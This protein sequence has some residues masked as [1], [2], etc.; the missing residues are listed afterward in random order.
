MVERGLAFAIRTPGELEAEFTP[1]WKN[2]KYRL[3]IQD[4]LLD[5]VHGQAGATRTIMA[6]LPGLTP[7]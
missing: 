5:Y 6:A 4:Q 2:E 7:S 3:R 1:L